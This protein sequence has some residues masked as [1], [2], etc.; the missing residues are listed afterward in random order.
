MANLV[1][2]VLGDDRAGLV[3]ALAGVVAKHGGN[4]ERSHMAELAGKFAG[5]VLVTAPA[6]A[7]DG[8]ASDLEGLESAGLFEV[9]VERAAEAIDT[10]PTNRVVLE[11]VGQDHPGI[12][13]DLSHAL[14]SRNVSIDE[15]QTEVEAAPMGGKLFRAK[16]VL[17]A[18]VGLS[19]DDLSET[20]EAIAQDLMVDVHLG[21]AD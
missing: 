2:T 19:L 9:L 14:A 5:I 12:V 17:E 11:L 18:P 13:Y 10:P 20:L 6:T 3:D 21:D 7:I 1:V 16:A 15:L 4:W 8:L